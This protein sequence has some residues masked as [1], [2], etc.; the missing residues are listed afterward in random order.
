MDT[1]NYW[2]E[3][4]RDLPDWA[5]TVGFVCLALMMFSTFLTSEG[6]NS[7]FRFFALII[8]G[9]AAYLYFLN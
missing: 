2:H 6:D 7:M 5:V 4:I 1:L 9:I 3:W 8:G